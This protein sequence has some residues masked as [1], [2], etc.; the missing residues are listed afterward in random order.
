MKFLPCD[1]F[2][3]VLCFLCVYSR[4]HN[5]YA[6]PA[7]VF[8]VRWVIMCMGITQVLIEPPA[9]FYIGVYILAILVPGTV[10]QVHH[11]GLFRRRGV[12]FSL[13]FGCSRCSAGLVA[14]AQQQQVNAPYPREHHASS[15]TTI[16]C[17]VVC[18]RRDN[19]PLISQ[20][21]LSMNSGNC[22]SWSSLPVSSYIYQ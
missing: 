1:L 15:T 20:S 6:L 18:R 10:Y 13:V 22:S 16:L 3:I 21:A 8:P 7:N 19:T 17:N 4:P 14:A 5:L 2:A 12:W 11:E 9:I